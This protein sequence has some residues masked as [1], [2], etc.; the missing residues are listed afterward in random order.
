MLL[1]TETREDGKDKKQWTH[2]TREQNMDWKKKK[3]T[4]SIKK[5]DGL[6]IQPFSCG[7][8]FYKRKMDRLLRYVDY[9]K[10]FG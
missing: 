4:A 5:E 1:E 9:A 6:H 7:T 10:Q 2:Y 8:I 3:N